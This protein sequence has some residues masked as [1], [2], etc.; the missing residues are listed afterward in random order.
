MAHA[1]K[2]PPDHSGEP[3][4]GSISMK[5]LAEHLGLSTAT[6]SLVL[7]R[8]PGAKSIPHTTQERIP[9]A[10]RQFNYRPNLMARRFRQ[11]RSFTIPVRLRETREGPSHRAF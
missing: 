1:K 3:A 10:A 8:S 7:N 9:A 4:G 11:K 6:L 5:A 2:L